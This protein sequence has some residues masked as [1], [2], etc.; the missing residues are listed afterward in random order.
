MKSTLF[1]YKNMFL[2]LSVMLTLGFFISYSFTLLQYLIWTTKTSDLHTKLAHNINVILIFGGG[3]ILG[4]AL[5]GVLSDFILLRKLGYAVLTITV[6]TFLSL[7]AAISTKGL[8]ITYLLYFLVGFSVASLG[9]W[10]L[11][12]CSKIYGGK[13]EAFAVT[14]QFIGI[15]VG[16]YDMGTI[17]FEGNIDM[18]L[19]LSL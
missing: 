13:F 2:T 1:W 3:A 8:F 18:Q 12:S 15:A 7:Y 10:L 11:C 17:M 4:G 9:C 5:T 16:V 6:G 19:K 14:A